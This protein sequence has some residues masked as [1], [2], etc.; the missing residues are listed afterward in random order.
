[1]TALSDVN[2]ASISS[3]DTQNDGIQVVIFK[4]TCDKKFVYVKQQLVR[5]SRLQLLLEHLIQETTIEFSNRQSHR[6]LI[7]LLLKWQT[8]LRINDLMR[9]PAVFW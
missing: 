3:F 7:F 2:A 6:I 5:G 1:M 9:K 4:W 8:T